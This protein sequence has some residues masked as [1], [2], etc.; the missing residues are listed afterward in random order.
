MAKMR[1]YFVKQGDYLESIAD[2][3]GFDPEEVWADK[4]NEKLRK[5]RKNPNILYPGMSCSYRT[6][7]LRNA[8]SRLGQRIPTW[9]R[10]SW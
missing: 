6:R 7:K 8:P 4:K 3:Y 10:R 1:P 5:K 9:L 2:C